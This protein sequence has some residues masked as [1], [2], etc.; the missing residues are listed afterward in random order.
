[1]R[2]MTL[3]KQEEKVTYFVDDETLTEKE[4]KNLLKKEEGEEED[5]EEPRV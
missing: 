5:D 2:N 1:M 3:I 4:L